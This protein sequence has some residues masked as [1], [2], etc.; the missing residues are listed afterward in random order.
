[1]QNA[2]KKLTGAALALTLAVVPASPARA[3]TVID[4][5][6]LAQNILQATR[7]LEQINNQIR[8]I[9]QQAQMLTRNPLQLSPELTQS[10]GQARELFGAAQGLTYQIDQ[11]SGQLRELYPDTW[12]SFDLANIGQRTRQW[13]REDRTAVEHAMAAQ[14]RAVQSIE[15]SQGQI[16]RA[17]QS[18]VGAEGQTGAVQA[19]NQLLGV[20]AAQLTEIH[21]LLIA[22]GRALETER[23]ERIAREERAQEIQRRAFPTQSNATVEPA[24]SAFNH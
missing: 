3:I 7:A 1:M 17:L 16:D 22:Q 5:T 6:N 14:A 10:I 23:M 8:Q 12:E 18:S 13:L 9:E 15:R 11:M 4:P 24:R 20:T 19:G 2:W 21:A